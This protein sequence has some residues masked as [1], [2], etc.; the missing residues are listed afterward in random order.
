MKGI[1]ICG[2]LMEGRCETPK[3]PFRCRGCSGDK[4]DPMYHLPSIATP[5][6]LSGETSPGT[7]DTMITK[8]VL[9]GRGSHCRT[10]TYVQSRARPADGNTDHPLHTGKI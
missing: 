5:S 4:L 1:L 6:P 2:F 10:V 7:G 3:G 8:A 9:P